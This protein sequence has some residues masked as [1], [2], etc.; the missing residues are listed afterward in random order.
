MLFEFNVKMTD[1]DYFK[2]NEFWLIRSHYGRSQ[3]VKMRIL[4]TVVSIIACIFYWITDGTTGNLFI[5]VGIDI[6]FLA[7]LQIFFGKFMALCLKQ[8]IKTLKKK[9]KMG[10]PPESLIQFDDDVIVETT[11]T[12]KTERSYSSLERVSVI[13][14]KTLYIHFN[15]VMAA[16]LPS[17]AFVSEEQYESF[18]AFIKTKCENID[19]Y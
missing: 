10:Y 13:G 5:L 17:T 19:V 6:F 9:G 3:M 12:E 1:D 15:N 8:Q 2:F 16:I 18:L 14:D 4:F 7:L 11:P